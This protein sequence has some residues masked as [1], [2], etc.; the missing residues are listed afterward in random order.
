[1][2][3]L[4]I[5]LAY[6]LPSPLHRTGMCSLSLSTPPSHSHISQVATGKKPRKSDY[7]EN[8]M[9]LL[10]IPILHGPGGLLC[11]LPAEL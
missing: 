7:S 6:A 3:S 8:I 5:Q 9:F 10:S 4:F 2:F 11:G 1:M